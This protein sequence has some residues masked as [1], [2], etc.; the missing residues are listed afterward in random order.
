MPGSTAWIWTHCPYMHLL[1]KV[2]K[3]IESFGAF[4]ASHDL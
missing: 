4:S 3:S 1:E 2:T